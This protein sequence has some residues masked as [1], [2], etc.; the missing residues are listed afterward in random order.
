MATI[1][2][3]HMA[4]VISQRAGVRAPGAASPTSP[5][6]G[7]ARS[8]FSRVS[9]TRGGSGGAA[10]AHAPVVVQVQVGELGVLAV[11]LHLDRPAGPAGAAADV[12]HLVFKAFGHVD[13]HAVLGPG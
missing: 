5:A 7:T 10:R 12:G 11:D 3:C 8:C 9:S 4:M 2:T 13:L 1:I 6:P